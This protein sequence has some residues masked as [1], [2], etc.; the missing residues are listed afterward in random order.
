MSRKRPVAGPKPSRRRP[1][2][3]NASGS[4]AGGDRGQDRDGHIPA[5][6]AS[7]RKSAGADVRGVANPASRGADSTCVDRNRARASAARRSR[8]GRHSPAVA[9]DVR[10]MAELE[11]MCARLA[12]RRMSD[13]DEQALGRP[14]G[15]ARPRAS[16]RITTITITRTN[17]SIKRYTP[18]RTTTFSSS[19]RSHCNAGCD[20]TDD[21]SYASGTGWRRRSASTRA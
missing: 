12:A 7:R 14:T 9:G 16:P 21:C 1:Q 5:W 10:A 19:R 15:R 11:A 4:L 2:S 18:P 17:A 8:C 6:H 3:G 20:R 13:S